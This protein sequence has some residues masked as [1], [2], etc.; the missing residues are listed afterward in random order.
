M[1]SDL[2]NEAI[3]TSL[4]FCNTVTTLRFVFAVF[5]VSLSCW[6]KEEAPSLLDRCSKAIRVSLCICG[7]RE[8]K[9]TNSPSCSRSTPTVIWHHVM[10]LRGLTG[11]PPP[12]FW[13][14]TY[15]HSWNQASSLQKTGMASLHHARNEGTSSQN[16]VL[17]HDWEEIYFRMCISEKQVMSQNGLH[18]NSWRHT[19]T[20]QPLS[21]NVSTGRSLSKQQEAAYDTSDSTRTQI[22]YGVWAL[23]QSIRPHT[24][25]RRTS[26]GTEVG[27][28]VSFYGFLC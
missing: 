11:T 14:V 8:K 20:S 18:C 13:D 22:T 4:L 10:A 2:A 16:S 12:L 28:C 21:D 24:R 19:E 26:S 5:T 27:F 17:I 15:S 6:K 9:E 3:I 23:I 7:V 25:I 1:G